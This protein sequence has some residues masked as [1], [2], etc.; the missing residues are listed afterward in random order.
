M[1]LILNI[2]KHIYKDFIEYRNKKDQIHREDGPAQIW[3][4]GNKSW[5]KNNKL[6]RT[7]GPAVISISGY[8]AWWIDG[9]QYSEK[10]Y[11]K[12]IEKYNL[13]VIKGEQI[14]NNSCPI[15]KKKNLTAFK[16]LSGEFKVFCNNC[17]KFV[18]SYKKDIDKEDEIEYNI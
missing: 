17:K 12:V 7:N 8:K 4:N 16:S 5:W 11:N 1:M 15:C 10:E 13:L 2:I 18:E 3:N 6:H 9:T 14:M